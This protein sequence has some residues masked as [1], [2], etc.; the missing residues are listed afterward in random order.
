METNMTKIT[1]K[2]QPDTTTI[3]ATDLK[4][5]QCGIYVDDSSCHDGS[6]VQ[7]TVLGLVIFKPALHR[8]YQGDGW[9]MET[10]RCSSEHR[11]RPILEMDVEIRYK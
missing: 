9:S 8:T 2:T 3:L 1:V 5:G 7:M 10:L 6:I 4:M 11:V